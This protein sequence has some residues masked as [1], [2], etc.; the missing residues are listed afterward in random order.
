MTRTHRLLDLAVFLAVL[1]AALWLLLGIAKADEALPMQ[2]GPCAP[3]DVARAEF[4]KTYGEEPVAA[5]VARGSMVVVL[6][7]PDGKTFTIMV[8]GPNGMACGIAAGSDWQA[9]QDKGL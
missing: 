9:K 7:S 5:G 1:G 3:W 8:V 6:A 4:K 2:A